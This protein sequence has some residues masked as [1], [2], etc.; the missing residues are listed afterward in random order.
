MNK[1]TLL[2][3]NGSANI[4]VLLARCFLRAGQ[5]SAC[6][7]F[8]IRCCNL[9]KSIQPPVEPVQQDQGNQPPQQH[10]P[11]VQN[12]PAAAQILPQNSLA[13]QAGDGTRGELEVLTKF[14]LFTFWL[15][16]PLRIFA[17]L[18]VLYLLFANEPDFARSGLVY[19]VV[20]VCMFLKCG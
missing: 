2:K 3:C 4:S 12:P 5:T 13:P 1:L 6:R 9:L 7:S 15:V 16:F 20:D 17:S 10:P 14:G 8:S 11:V 18:H 19:H